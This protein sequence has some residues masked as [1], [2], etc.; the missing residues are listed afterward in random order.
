MPRRV[1]VPNDV[2]R[3]A[4]SHECLQNRPRQRF[5]ASIPEVI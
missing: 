3:R 4:L 2:I 1:R 5:G